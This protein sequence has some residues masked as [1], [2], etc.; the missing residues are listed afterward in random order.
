MRVLNDNVMVRVENAGERVTAAGLYVPETNMEG[1]VIF[2]EVVAVGAG[3][4]LDS[5]LR[6][7]MNVSIGDTVWFPK[8]NATLVVVGGVKSYVVSEQSIVAVN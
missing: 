8:F 4:M 7:T 2:G 1:Q 5:G 3:K 6:A